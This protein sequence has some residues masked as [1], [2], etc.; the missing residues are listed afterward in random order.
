LDNFIKNLFTLMFRLV[1]MAA[2]FIFI[3]S[4]MAAGL[5]L[6]AVWLLRA[7]FARLTGRP[8]TPWAFQMNR[9]AVWSR[10]YKAPGQTSEANHRSAD[11]IDAEVK[12]V[13]E[14][15]FLDR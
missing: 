15:R 3:A 6:M 4:L 1:L 9:Q 8:V 13:K 2:G 7:L 12:E 14:T 10:F 5:L 11:V